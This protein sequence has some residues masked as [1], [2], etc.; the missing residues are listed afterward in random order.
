MASNG[1]HSAI[2]NVDI[3]AFTTG[4]D[5]ESRRRT[6]RELAT[7]CHPHGCISLTGHGVPPELLRE[8]FAV[9]KRLFDLPLED[10]MKAPHPDGYIPHR[11]YSGIGKEQASGKAG[12]ETNDEV[13]KRALKSMVDYKVCFPLW[14]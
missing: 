8:T 3:S 9:T 12:V 10:K 6:A 1:I 2:P 4:G 5:L 14:L 13:H 7:A 11:G